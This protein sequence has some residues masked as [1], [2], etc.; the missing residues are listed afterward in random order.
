VVDLALRQLQGQAHRALGGRRVAPAGVF[1]LV[2]GEPVS[3][4]HAAD[5]N[6][7]DTTNRR[8]GG[9]IEQRALGT[10]VGQGAHGAQVLLDRRRREISSLE[11][12]AVALNTGQ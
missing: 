6:A 12:D 9:L 2:A 10:L 8:G 3:H 5:R 11:D 1:S 4:P 7:F